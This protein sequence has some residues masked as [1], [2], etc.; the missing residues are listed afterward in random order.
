MEFCKYEFTD[1]QWSNLKKK[2]EATNEN[3]NKFFVGCSVV[4]LGNIIS[5]EIVSKKY[6]VDIL[7]NDKPLVEF[8][9]YE[10]YPTPCGVHLFAGWE[11]IYAAKYCKANPDS[12]YCQHFNQ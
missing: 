10:V 11:S 2:I 4:E 12:E 8:N 1:L 7:W 5:N 6:S 3:G 9:Q